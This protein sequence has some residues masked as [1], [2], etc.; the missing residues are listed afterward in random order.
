MPLG[1]EKVKQGETQA[2][3]SE[4]QIALHWMKVIRSGV[5]GFCMG[6]RRAITLASREADSVKVSSGRVFTLGPLIHNPVALND[7]K[8]QGVEELSETPRNLEG[9]S[10]VICAHGI[11]PRL[12]EG[13]RNKGARVVD[14][15]CPKVKESQL[16][17]KALAED[18]FT[19]FLAGEA[20]HAEIIGI[21]GYTGDAGTVVS[22]ASEAEAAAK[23]LYETDRNAKTALLGQTT[24]S[25]EE[26]LSISEAVKKYFPDLEIVLTICAA[27]G[28][29]QR[30]LRELLEQV[31]AVI[32]AGGK[33]SANTRRLLAIARKSGKPCVLVETAAE[34]PT[35]FRAYEMVGLCAG[36]SSPD[37]VIDEIERELAAVNP[38]SPNA[39]SASVISS[40]G[41]A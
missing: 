41:M 36:A 25:E 27:T 24:I 28:D 29:R 40:N 38:I 1:S 18:G 20:R 23:R 9:S 10:L 26:Y 30:A 8:K 32:I 35:S 5:L 31:D 16:R 13:M 14:A 6:V 17:A 21:L 15:T 34:I 11:D 22:N 7:L 39:F 12:E 2:S 33:E 3:A 19:L 4:S 37:S